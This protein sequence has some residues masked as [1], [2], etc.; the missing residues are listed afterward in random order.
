MINNINF[1]A[2]QL[3]VKYRPHHGAFNLKDV[4][5]MDIV[6]VDDYE[7]GMQGEQNSNFAA[8]VLTY[9]DK[10]GDVKVLNLKNPYSPEVKTININ[11]KD[12]DKI[13]AKTGDLDLI[14]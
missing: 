13:V 2:N 7:K 4:H 8:I 3:F 12:D 9:P 1:C 11:K 10:K 6:R 14:A 5:P